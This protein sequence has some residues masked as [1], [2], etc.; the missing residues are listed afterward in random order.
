METERDRY[1]SLTLVKS[2]WFKR[3]IRRG[4]S[5]G[6]KSLTIVYLKKKLIIKP[7]YAERH[8]G[9]VSRSLGSPLAGSFSSRIFHL[10]SGKEL[11]HFKGR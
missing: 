11:V 1:T 8:V 10:H 4:T 5:D 2:L 3:K 9:N 7:L 6:L